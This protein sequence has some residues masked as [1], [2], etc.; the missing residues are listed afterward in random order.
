MPGPLSLG[1]SFLQVAHS[2]PE[3]TPSH[4]ANTDYGDFWSPSVSATCTSYPY[5]HQAIIFT[6]ALQFLVPALIA[7]CHSEIWVYQSV[8]ARLSLH[9]CHW[10]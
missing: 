10:P 9:S 4:T 3:N 7:L 1:D 6:R 2:T 5:P 8:T